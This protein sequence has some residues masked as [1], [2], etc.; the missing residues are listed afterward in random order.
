M[1]VTFKSIDIGHV[2]NAYQDVK[3][4]FSAK[5]SKI[6]AKVGNKDTNNFV[7]VITKKGTSIWLDWTT[8]TSFI[9]D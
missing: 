7:L 4:N 2:P 1:Y 9:L 6:P 8:V 3:I 5:P